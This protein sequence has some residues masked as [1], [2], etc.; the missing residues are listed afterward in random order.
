[1][2]EFE[3][4]QEKGS[5]NIM[6]SANV[7]E[8]INSNIEE[9]R[10]ANIKDVQNHLQEFSKLFKSYRLDLLSCKNS[11]KNKLKSLLNDLKKNI[12][13]GMNEIGTSLRHRQYNFKCGLCNQDITIEPNKDMWS[14]LQD[15]EHFEQLFYHFLNKEK[16][17]PPLINEIQCVNLSESDSSWTSDD[18]TV[19]DDCSNS[20]SGIEQQTMEPSTSRLHSSNLTN[21]SK[22]PPTT[23][24]NVN[25]FRFNFKLSYDS[26]V[27]SKIYPPSIMDGIRKYDKLKE[28]S[29]MKRG[30]TIAAC[31]IC[32]CDM[33]GLRVSK[34]LL[35]NHT[36]GQKHLRAARNE[37]S[38]NTLSA[39]H[40][41]WVKQ[42]PPIQAHQVY[43]WPLIRSLTKME[44]ALC[45]TYVP[46]E[47][48]LAH[49]MSVPHKKTVLDM[50]E[51][52][53]NL[54]Y[55]VP[56]QVQA[57]GITKEEVETRENL[58]KSQRSRE[59]SGSETAEETS[60]STPKKD[61]RNRKEVVHKIIKAV[62]DLDS[63]DPLELLPNRMKGESVFFQR[64]TVPV[65]N[66][67]QHLIY[68][69]RCEQRIKDDFYSIR[70]HIMRSPKH[71]K[72]KGSYKYFCEVCSVRMNGEADWINH[73]VGRRHANPTQKLN[74]TEY[75]CVPCKTVIFGDES[76]LTRHLS[77]GVK[78]KKD[79]DNTLSP[80]IKA[81]FESK[82]S[83]LDRAKTLREA[84]EEVIASPQTK[85]CC[86]RLKEALSVL[87]GQCDV[88]PFGSRISGIGNKDSDLDVFIDVG[89]TYFGEY[90]QDPSD[91]VAFIRKATKIVADQKIHQSP[92]EFCKARQV[93][94]ARTPILTLHH[95]PTN[96]DCDLSFKHGLSV[97]NT[98]FL[99]LCLQL[100]P[101]CQELI[102]LVKQW[103][104][105]T[106]FERISTYALAI[107]C[108]FYMQSNGHLPSVEGIRRLN[109]VP[110]KSING[111]KTI[112]CTLSLD[113][114]K[115]HVKPYEKSCYDLLKQFFVY[116]SKFDFNTYVVCPLLG[117]VVNRSLFVDENPDQLPPEMA[118]YVA[119]LE[120]EDGEVFRSHSYMCVQDP[121]DLSHNLTKAVQPGTVKR[122]Q[123]NCKLCLE[124]MEAFERGQ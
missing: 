62:E 110:H 76:S 11:K 47:N 103:A 37:S 10:A 22:Y 18:E 27:E 68:C 80:E 32:N 44:C 20:D 122:F 39:F 8:S 5:T 124:L 1:M 19:S 102:L 7:D 94:T 106:I 14:C 112:N 109:D 90:C 101:A 114:L 91:Q 3:K 26:E 113:N 67:F 87:F 77:I 97:E 70:N 35:F 71:D 51:Q 93:L 63:L 43:F 31:M 83:I 13:E 107:M 96:L 84:A 108:I 29:I 111:W 54:V 48:I 52:R 118:D 120:R 28:Y 79:K 30:A 4:N 60:K 81:L 104:G 46:N 86:D 36:M 98:K 57:Y 123:S 82:Q 24:E 66:G 58:E 78:K 95:T 21:K 88:Y 12:A 99:R 72:A 41:F 25:S 15:H 40:A 115:K 16:Y 116:Y 2:S 45:G 61:R 85:I 17:D 9:I 59:K 100:E 49:I 50:Y 55:L 119:Q 121:F 92:R 64:V 56:L 69:K 33:N 105:L 23:E 73:L 53:N 117:R 38:I 6:L 65:E 75:E 34:H 74:L 42:D 89:G